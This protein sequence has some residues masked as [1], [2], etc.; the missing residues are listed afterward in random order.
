MSIYKEH[1][2][3]GNF[4]VID[5]SEGYKIKR[6]LVNPDGKLSLQSH[7]QRAEHWVVTKGKAKI[8]V[9]D[10]V[11]FYGHGQYIYIPQGAKHRLENVTNNDV[12][13]VEIQCGQYLGE[14][15]IV[16]YEDVYSR[17]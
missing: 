13:V 10:E 14:D 15:D 5:E 2:P 9:D 3:W 6:I 4:T 12:E 11:Y 8:S 16:R 7:S 17:V 1:R